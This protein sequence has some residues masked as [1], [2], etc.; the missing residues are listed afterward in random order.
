MS[1]KIFTSNTNNSSI[2][3][4]IK[5]LGVRLK[6]DESNIVIVPDRF[7]LDTEK[8]IFDSL[9]IAGSAN[10]DV[11]SFT[12][13]AIKSVG[14]KI[15]K[16]LSKEGTLMLLKS[17][18]N[19][20]KNLLSHYKHV[21]QLP[22]F[23]KEVFIAI[24]SLKKSGITVEEIRNAL[25]NMNKRTG[26]KFKDIALLYE[27]YDKE[28]SARYSDTISRLDTLIEHIPYNNKI[29]SSNIYI[30]GYNFFDAKQLEI[31]STFIKHSKSCNISICDPR[32]NKSVSALN[33]SERLRAIAIKLGATYEVIEGV[34]ALTPPFDTV[35]SKIFTYSKIE[36]KAICNDKLM[37]FSE[38]NPYDEI[39]AAGKEIIR[40][41]REKN[42]RFK[43]FAVLSNS[44]SYKRVI[45]DIFTRYEIPHYIDIK[46]PII[47]DIISSFLLITLDALSS[48]F[49]QKKVI[50]LSKHPFM[51][52]SREDAEIFEDYCLKYNISYS[53]FKDA[54]TLG[55][56]NEK[57]TAENVRKNLI[58]KLN[59]FNDVNLTYADIAI[60]IIAY[61]DFCQI[62][63]QHND[64]I[65]NNDLD[66][67]TKDASRQVY[68]K[69][70]NVL[71]E[72]IEILGS[73]PYSIKE[74]YT[75][76]SSSLSNL[77]I[78][79][80]PQYIDAVFVGGSEDSLFRDLKV[81]F[82]VGANQGSFPEVAS[83]QSIINYYDIDSL[84]KE[85]LSLYPTPID[86]MQESQFHILDLL[87]KA[88]EKC[89]LSYAYFDFTG[90]QLNK[91]EV[92][93]DIQRLTDAKI[94]SLTRAFKEKSMCSERDFVNYAVNV[95]N[96]FYEYLNLLQEHPQ[97]TP[98][99][100][101]IKNHLL[102]KGYKDKLD[103]IIGVMSSA[104]SLPLDYFFRKEGDYYT[105]KVSQL[106]QYFSCPYKH[107]LSYGLRLKQKEKGDFEAVDIGI[108]VHDILE[109]YF[110][111]Y[112]NVIRQMSDEDIVKA[113]ASI[114]EQVMHKDEIKAKLN[115]S[116]GVRLSAL[117]IK[118]CTECIFALSK[119]IT[120]GSFNPHFIEIQF[121]M[122]EEGFEGI[123]IIEGEDKFLLRGKVDRVDT[124][125]NN[126]I[127]IDYK[128]GSVDDSHTYDKLYFGSK[129]QL[130]IYLKAFLKKGF[131]PK[132]LFYLPV[133]LNYR[134]T[135]TKKDFRLIGHFDNSPESIEMLDR[136]VVE[137]A[138][139]TGKS[140]K[141]NIVDFSVKVSKGNPEISSSKSYGL[142]EEEFRTLCDY[143]LKLTQRAIGEIK[144]GYIEKK[145]FED[146]CTYCNYLS[147]CGSVSD[148][149]FRRKPK[150]IN[151]ELLLKGISND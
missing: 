63:K 16:T 18:I 106:E 25:N 136:E 56:E 27:E 54:F 140:T 147:I 17:V 128:T 6:A 76:I 85:G 77:N 112:K 109:L 101:N 88:E 143:T 113:S 55:K 90:T 123:E 145:P 97:D 81:M 138:I 98:L 80:I 146:G 29:K 72:G 58:T 65:D 129:I 26:N 50:A 13:L 38:L 126:I 100:L 137:E 69:I 14:D 12:R 23:A 149:E 99:L 49:K 94:F 22:L 46:F 74:F 35:C 150:G 87:T 44:E 40:L 105:T 83:Y 84:K 15:K 127:I 5:D 32:H 118:E 39:K 151:K 66:A 71:E 10:V 28:L 148:E 60:K 68:A 7:S 53:Y 141:S 36:N 117:I 24:A 11:V 102:E 124:F 89:Y 42:M 67:A 45:K 78:S 132:G 119:N 20:N 9:Q 73:S 116:N 57:A 52:I 64:Y 142:T 86:K 120:M 1:L 3:L 125:G 70:I 122:G 48:N 133:S 21:S 4:A 121:G 95:K 110:K 96:L 2:R 51:D 61:L 62:E 144:S 30:L 115:K 139:K 34:K 104:L 131:I 43:D 130:F 37:I 31:I 47:N 114:I 103:K 107:F 82:I 33:N 8:E 92:I 93:K 108:I 135:D 59:F 19:K 91:G 134:A 75:L 111:T 79:V 41:I